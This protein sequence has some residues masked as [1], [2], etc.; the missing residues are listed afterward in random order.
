MA[1]EMQLLIFVFVLIITLSFMMLCAEARNLHAFQQ[2]AMEYGA[3][4]ARNLHDAFQQQHAMAPSAGGLQLNL[5]M[6]SLIQSTL[7]GF[8]MLP[9]GAIPPSGPSTPTHSCY[10]YC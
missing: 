8:G 4:E 6:Q 3:A 9:R 10:Y 7:I 1:K 5:Q 2:Q